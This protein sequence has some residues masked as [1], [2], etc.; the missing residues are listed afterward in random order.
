MKSTILGSCTIT[1]SDRVFEDA[2]LSSYALEGL[3]GGAGIAFI[4]AQQV[5]LYELWPALL[6]ANVLDTIAILW[7][8]FVGIILA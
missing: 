5:T 8:A 1:H 3:T 4:I 6:C 7:K 2:S